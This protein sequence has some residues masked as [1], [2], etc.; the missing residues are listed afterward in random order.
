MFN[1]F[2]EYLTA[3]GV[4]WLRLYCGLFHEFVPWVAAVEE[5]GKFL[6]VGKGNTPISFTSIPEVAA[7]LAHV[8]TT[9]P[10]A[11]LSNIE[12]RIEGQRASL[13]EL[14]ELYTASTALKT[15]VLVEHVDA[16]PLPVGDN[17]GYLQA[18]F[19]LGAGSS[20]WDCVE[21]RD[22]EALARSGNALWEGHRWEGVKEVLRL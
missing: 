15:P 19:A 3:I 1:L 4:P 7:Y 6:I 14:G 17:R 18:K 10:R 13:S 11:R 21:E 8:L 2:I 5:T 16:L 22:N 9:V 12:L 20:G